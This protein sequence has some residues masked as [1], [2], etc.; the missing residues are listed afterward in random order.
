MTT[1]TENVHQTRWGYVAT[2]YE[3]YQKLRRLQYLY[4][5]S[6][7]ADARHWRWKRK[8]PQNRIERSWIRNGK[9]QKIDCVKGNPIPEPKSGYAKF[10]NDSDVK[11]KGRWLPL[12]WG[13]LIYEDYRRAKF[14]K[15]NPEEVES[16]RLTDEQID[17][18]LKEAEAWFKS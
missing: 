11:V 6:E 10:W 8:E 17:E 16:I 12:R 2:D 18:M 7:K 3:T 13:E 1:Q 4:L 14:P 15:A 9:G 5:L